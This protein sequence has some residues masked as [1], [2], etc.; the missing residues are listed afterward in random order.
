MADEELTDQEQMDRMVA[1]LSEDMDDIN[2]DGKVGDQETD[3]ETEKTSEAEGETEGQEPGEAKT[4]SEGEDEELTDQ[5][6]MDRMVA[7]LSEDMDDI[8]QDG[9]VGDQ[10]TDQET[11]ETTVDEGEAE[12]EE[13]ESK[14]PGTYEEIDGSEESTAERD[15]EQKEKDSEKPTTGKKATPEK[16]AIEEE[17]DEGRTESPAIGPDLY[18]EES[19]ADEDARDKKSEEDTDALD[20]YEYPDIEEDDHGGNRRRNAI[21]WSIIAVLVLGSASVWF[22]YRKDVK[23]LE[24]PMVSQWAQKLKLKPAVEDTNGSE[25]PLPKIPAAELHV[26]TP[27]AS[28]SSPRAEVKPPSL[29]KSEMFLQKMQQIL[30]VRDQLFEKRALAASMREELNEQILA[31]QLE[32]LAKQRTMKITSYTNAVKSPRIYYNIKLIQQLKAYTSKLSERIRYYEDGYDKMNF[33]YQEADDTFKIIE[34]WSDEKTKKLMTK[35]DKAINEYQ[36]ENKPHMFTN[37]QIVLD[38]PRNIWTKI[39]KQLKSELDG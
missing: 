20:E 39:P 26:K 28:V 22:A 3:Q 4:E 1:E 37:K 35:I 2:Q 5:E 15:R 36:T 18:P 23:I 17:K 14:A 11:E 33:R 24:H 9:N 29:T 13:K 19:N 8:N 12:E 6:Q 10:E 21:V 32:I 7:E 25:P 30:A 31:L 16:P 27:Q 38:T 34:L